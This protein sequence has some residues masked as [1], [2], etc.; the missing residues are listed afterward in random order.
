MADF[1]EVYDVESEDFVTAGDA[2]RNIKRILKK[3]GLDANLIRRI[4]IASYESEM[5]MAIHSYGGTITFE[6][7]D[8]KVLI[9]CK[10]TGPGIE[11]IKRAMQEGYSTASKSARAIG[12]GAGMGLPNIRNNADDMNLESS[13]KGTTL[14]VAFNIDEI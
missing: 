13:K 8:N 5:N 4:A 11:D 1:F 7:E 3:I 9:T 2:S 10:D 12:F 14:K 6:I